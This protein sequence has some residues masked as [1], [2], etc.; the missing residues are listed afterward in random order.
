MRVGGKFV[1]GNAVFEVA[2]INVPNPPKL[3]VSL[4]PKPAEIGSL[5]LRFQEINAIIC[6]MKRKMYK[7]MQEWKLL[8]YMVMFL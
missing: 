8:F 4:V 6:A 3:V 1:N 2:A 7:K 5:L